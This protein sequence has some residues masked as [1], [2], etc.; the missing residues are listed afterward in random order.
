MNTEILPL[1][2]RPPRV[3][4]PDLA[5]RLSLVN[6]AIRALHKYGCRVRCQDLRR[7]SHK[8]P[9]LMIDAPTSDLL[10]YC[11]GLTRSAEAGVGVITRVFWHDIELSWCGVGVSECAA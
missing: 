11:G 10:R 9:L 1:S 5:N 4:T 2:Q 7:G 6:D 3:L 8:R